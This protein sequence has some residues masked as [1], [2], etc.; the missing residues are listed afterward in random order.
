MPGIYEKN[1]SGISQLSDIFRYNISDL[2]LFFRGTD[3][4]DGRGI[5]KFIQIGHLF[6]Y[7]LFFLPFLFR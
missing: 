4:R 1:F 3:N 7:F 5:E 6:L 2:P